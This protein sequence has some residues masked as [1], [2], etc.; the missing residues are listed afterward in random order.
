MSEVPR[1]WGTVLHLEEPEVVGAG[2]TK[3]LPPFSAHGITVGAS[4]HVGG[5]ER[6]HD[7]VR[8][9]SGWEETEKADQDGVGRRP[10]SHPPGGGGEPA[11]AP[12][13]AAPS[14]GR[15]YPQLLIDPRPEILSVEASSVL[16]FVLGSDGV[17]DV[18]SPED[19]ARI[20]KA[21]LREGVGA[22]EV[23]RRVVGAAEERWTRSRRGAD[24][25]VAA[26]GILH[27]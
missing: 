6:Q 19:A 16:G 18:I 11:L 3:S 12:P 7:F 9:S 8:V 15:L 23:A 22:E 26:V 13:A 10:D 21:G 4:E 25:V 5:K 27:H 1:T 14:G 17:W 20:V 2:E 24:N